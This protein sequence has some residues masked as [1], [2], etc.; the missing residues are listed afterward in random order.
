LADVR[1]RIAA[2]VQRGG[3]G[4]SVCLIA[5]TK[6]HGPDAV[7][8]AFAAG[9][10]DVGENKV[11]EA[12]DKRG[13]V[14][15]PAAAA[16]WHMIGHLQSNKVRFLDGFHLVHSV[17]RTSLADTIST[18]GLKRTAPIDVLVQVNVVGEWTKGGYAPAMIESEA[19][20]LHTLPGLK[21]RG[22]MAMAP[23]DATEQVLRTVFQGARKTR[24]LLLQAG[25]DA[26]ELSMGMSGDYEIAV[27]EGATMVRLGSVLFGA[28]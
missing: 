18:W 21:V 27:E 25:H 24:E 1:G 23:F 11:Q 10:Q 26:Q 6:T 17:D 2:A 12:L 9:I 8:A 19:A 7:E 22:V 20:R 4:Q 15:G 28:R 16:R 14:T 3:H 13:R 5:V